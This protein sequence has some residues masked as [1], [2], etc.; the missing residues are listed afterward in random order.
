MKRNK[1]L[2]LALFVFTLGVFTSCVTQEAS[3]VENPKPATSETAETAEIREAQKIVKEMP[4]SIIGYNKLAIAYIRRARE[5]GDFSLNSKAEEAV[6]RALK[7][8]EDNPEAQ[9][10]KG[11]LMLTFHRFQEA[12]QYGN[13]LLEK[14]PNDA[15]VLGI[16]TD[17]NVEL[18]NYKEALDR[19]QQMVSTRPNTESYTRVS[20]LRS[21]YGD[22]DGAIEAMIMAT[23]M[24]SPTDKEVKAWCLAHLGNEYFQVG[25][26]DTAEFTYDKTLEFFPGYHFALEG[27]GKTRAAQGDYQGAIKYYTQA[28]ERVPLTETVIQLGNVYSKTGEKE[29]AE[30]QYELAEVI[31]K[32]L[33]NTDQ[34]RLALMWADLDVNLDKALE[35]AKK[36]HANR[37]DIYTADIYAWCLYKKGN[38]EEARKIIKEAMR[39]DTKDAQIYYHAGMIEKESG[40]KKAAAEYLKKALE[41]NPHFDILQSEKAKSALESVS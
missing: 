33:G 2:L 23:K 16:L 39:L 20:K 25:K 32:N 41:I 27:K 10:L 40:N 29:K 26:I 18:G 9:K 34:R 37:R 31:E 21:L 38:Y 3:K 15:F 1:I 19:G 8:D 12:L 6:K 14:Y 5:T 24:A 17:A 36:E 7:I 11:S 30:Q 28:Q 13:E 35:I 22:S 4:D